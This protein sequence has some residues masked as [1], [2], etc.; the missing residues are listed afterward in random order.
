M[1]DALAR[2][3]EAEVLAVED[4][5]VEEIDPEWD[6]YLSDLDYWGVECETCGGD[7]RL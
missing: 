1:S 5:E 3:I 2:L 6:A 4:D 7:C